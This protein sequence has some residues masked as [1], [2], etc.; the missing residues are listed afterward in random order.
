MDVLLRLV[1]EERAGRPALWFVLV[2]ARGYTL[3]VVLPLSDISLRAD[4]DVA[5][6]LLAVLGSV[7]AEEDPGGSVLVGMV[8]AEG[9]DRGAFESSWAR[10][11]RDAAEAAGVHL[12]G[13]A[14]IGADRARMLEW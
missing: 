2:D 14:A 4:P 10:A 13:I 9:G 6:G 3:P 11:L 7:L 5:R 1:G 8:R 12:W